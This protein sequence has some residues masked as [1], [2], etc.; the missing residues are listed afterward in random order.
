MLLFLCEKVSSQTTSLASPSPLSV[1]TFHINMKF[2]FLF[3][4]FFR[5]TNNKK[6]LD[7]PCRE[8][9]DSLSSSFF[10]HYCFFFNRMFHRRKDPTDKN[11]PTISFHWEKLHQKGSQGY[12]YYRDSVG[13]S[14][15]LTLMISRIYRRMD[16]LGRDNS[17]FDS[18]D[19]VVIEVKMIEHCK[20]RMRCP[21][22][23]KG[24]VR[25]C[26]LVL[27]W[28]CIFT[29]VLCSIDS[30]SLTIIDDQKE[31]ETEGGWHLLSDVT[32]VV[33]IVDK[34]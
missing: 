28:C 33:T 30:P 7:I 11:L 25:S 10:S 34:I 16:H 22:K 27:F 17:P 32:D 6:P 23:K 19:E 2:V 5:V 3:G 13:V 12:H 8:I 9:K 20:M 1:S 14:L 29:L 26:R 18:A 31:D 24:Q 15:G 21:D 4:L